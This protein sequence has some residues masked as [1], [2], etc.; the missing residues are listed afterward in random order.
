MMVKSATADR[1]SAVRGTRRCV[2]AYCKPAAIARQS[3][4]H[5]TPRAG[6]RS[7]LGGRMHT[8]TRSLLAAAGFALVLAASAALAQNPPTVR[9]RGT[10]E[11][12]DGDALIVRSRDG[13]ELKVVP[14]A[15]PLIIAIVKATVADI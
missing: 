3:T 6:P 4:L 10:I 11:K 8:V 5:R 14:A 12:V 1:S 2:R 7:M 15:N 9:V 13:A